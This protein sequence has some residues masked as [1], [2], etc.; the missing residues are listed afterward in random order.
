MTLADGRRDRAA[1]ATRDRHPA[2][3]RQRV[4]LHGDVAA[5]VAPSTGEDEHDARKGEHDGIDAL[6]AVSRW[7]S[8]GE[9]MER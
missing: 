1:R 4:D 5:I 3:Q 2:S 6:D 7:R 9:L 8:A